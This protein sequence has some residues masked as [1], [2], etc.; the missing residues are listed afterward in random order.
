M[1]WV[2]EASQNSFAVPKRQ[3]GEETPCLV[4]VRGSEAFN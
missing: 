3:A 2:G 1:G 4:R